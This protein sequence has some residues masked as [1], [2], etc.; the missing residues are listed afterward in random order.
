M[1]LSRIIL[2]VIVLIS[3]N[4]S[5]QTKQDLRFEEINTITNEFIKNNF[6]S[7]CIDFLKP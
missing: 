3:S 5:S 7:N 1:N 4:L 2:L 6:I